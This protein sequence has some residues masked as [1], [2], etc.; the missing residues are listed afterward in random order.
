MCSCRENVAEYYNQSGKYARLWMGTK[1]IFLF[2]K[3][4]AE[5]FSQNL[6]AAIRPHFQA[7]IM[8][9]GSHGG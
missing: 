4:W 1:Y 5:P 7:I 2:V 9:F 6:P 3:G 8:I